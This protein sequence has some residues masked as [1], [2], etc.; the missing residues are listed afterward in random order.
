MA[1]PEP[2][3]PIQRRTA[4]A[5]RIRRLRSGRD[6]RSPTGHASCAT[7]ERHRRGSG[8]LPGGQPR[9]L[10]AGRRG[11]RRRRPVR[12]RRDQAAG[13]ASSTRPSSMSS[14]PTAMPASQPTITPYVDRLAGGA[15]TSDLETLFQL[16]HL[17]MTPTSL[18]PGGPRPAP[19]VRT[20]RSSRTRPSDPGT[21][22]FDALLDTRYGGELRYTAAADTRG[23]RHARSRAASSGCG[24]AASATP[25][26][27]CSRSPATSTSTS[28]VDLAAATSPRLPGDGTVR[29]VGRRRG[30]PRRLASS[31]VTV[32][33]GTGDT[34]V[35]VA[36]VHHA[37]G[38]ADR[39]LRCGPTSTSS[40]RCCRPV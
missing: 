22:G 30:P 10:V 8:R 31:D 6:R 39:R 17:Y 21:A 26:T 11:R 12:G 35:A 4:R 14:S 7:L 27:G 23:V 36:A 19:A 29:A 9:R 34:V 18:R 3:A 40:P 37:R 1:A 28:C 32:Q 13:S 15:A 2:V 33:A 20:H 24:A 25:A 38:R 5:R 16:V